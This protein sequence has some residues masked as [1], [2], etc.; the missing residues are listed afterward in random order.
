MRKFNSKKEAL[1]WLTEVMNESTTSHGN[2]RVALFKN[3]RAMTN[4]NKKVGASSSR[5]RVDLAV[6]IAGDSATIGCDVFD[7]EYRFG[8]RVRQ[9]K[10]LA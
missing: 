9:L 8:G 10:P 2:P 5:W 6:L 4:Y 7:M 1:G 3:K